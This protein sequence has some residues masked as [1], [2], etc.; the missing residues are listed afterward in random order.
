M[1]QTTKKTLD[2]VSK[3]L[4]LASPSSGADDPER[5]SAA[6]ELIN[7]I[8]KQGLKI[9]DA[10]GE[11]HKPPPLKCGNPLSGV[12]VMSVAPWHTG[13]SLCGKL[14]SPGDVVVAR[15]IPE[16][17]VEYRHNTQQCRP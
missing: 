12:W 3:L 4:R 6:L 11:E 13:C 1:S 10:R 7:Q 15:V 17:G 2:L 9:T 16:R 14:I 8:E 5:A